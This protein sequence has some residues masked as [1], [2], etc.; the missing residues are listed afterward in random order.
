LR[1]IKLEIEGF[2]SFRDR[3]VVDFT[4]TDLFVLTG[5]TGSGKSSVIDAMT[6]ALY[7]SIPRLDNQTTIAP[8]MSRGLL[9]TLVRLDFAIGEKRYVA[10]RQIRATKSGGA[11]TSEARLEDDQGN[12][13]A[14]NESELTA[15]VE[16]L[17]GIPFDHFIKCVVLPQGD[18]ADFIHAKPAA[19]QEFLID[20]LGLDLFDQVGSRAGQ[21]KSVAEG[22]LSSLR[23]QIERLELDGYSDTA[24]KDARARSKLI[25]ETSDKVVAQRP[26][27][28]ALQD[29]NR[30]ASDRIKAATTNETRLN[31]LKKP[32]GVG[33]LA[34][35]IRKASETVLAGRAVVE[36]AVVER[37]A[38]QEELN[39]LPDE[40]ETRTHIQQ[41]L[42]LAG[43]KE[44]KT[45][46]ELRARKR[47]AEVVRAQED[48]ESAGEVLRTA[49]SEKERVANT[50]IA[51]HLAD[52]LEPG[53]PCPVCFR[54]IDEPLVHETPPEEAAAVRCLSEAE[55]V[56]QLC[57]EALQQAQQGLAVE[58]DR[59]EQISGNI[60]KLEKLLV[61]VK[62]EGVLIA[63]LALVEDTKL[64]L[65]NLND[66]ERGA[67]N[68]F[69]K[70]E[71]ARNDLEGVSAKAWKSYEQTRD[72]VAELTP[73][74]ANR[75]NLSTAWDDLVKWSKKA[76]VEQATLRNIAEKEQK[77]A[78][79]EQAGVQEATAKLCAD[80]DLAITG[81]DD[82][83]A[84]CAAELGRLKSLVGQIQK[85]LSDL[86][87][88]GQEAAGLEMEVQLSAELSRL[89]NAS[90]FKRWLM[91]RVLGQLSDTA[92]VILRELS[93]GAY[94]LTVDGRSN[95]L[96][97]DHFNAN[98]QRPI[99][100]LSGGE[101][102]LASLSLA[103]ALSEHLA[104]M[105]IS[106]SAKLE[107]LFLDEGFGTLDA[108]TLDVVTT[109]I[110]E[111]GAQGRMIGI[112]THVKDLADRIPIRFEVA[113]EG[114]R[115][116]I[117]R[118][119]S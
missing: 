35:T 59:V 40:V 89:L 72:Q 53:E 3:T 75:E 42:D 98:E 88:L 49:E 30:S 4:D 112:V 109:A 96:V 90:N 32:D 82:A 17:L 111:L 10:V 23:S 73:P 99:R 118:I 57:A 50:H 12:T 22:E 31:V 63:D 105:A 74:S 38:A 29:R 95:F 117:T 77:E 76:V 94:S 91:R 110:E 41:R 60:E 58:K 101:T 47:A 45:K 14:A 84:V 54:N 6:F 18:F 9:Q 48:L 119:A 64:A 68:D 92:S 86:K 107:A 56:E 97:I 66:V 87:A 8:I 78:Q 36:K 79:S 39:T 106:G 83:Y 26:I 51:Y 67:Q 69:K 21:R 1:P 27:L 114:N 34:D 44:A 102:F 80:V 115:S 65:A 70:A 28:E 13:L 25:K 19:R 71:R 11:T 33:E 103:L 113:K 93:S 5:A 100:T 104:E 108:D 15:E 46:A 55:D 52:G 7:G 20:L 37:Q 2:T 62:A 16:A 24:L 85:T 81:D 116:S 43:Q 61:S